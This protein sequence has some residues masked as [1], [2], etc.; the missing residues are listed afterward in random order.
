MPQISIVSGK[1]GTGKTTI[2]G[3]FSYLFKKSVIA[4]CDVDAADLHLIVDP[5]ILKSEIFE[6][7]QTAKIDKSKCAQCGTCI[8][9]CRFDAINDNFEIDPLACEGCGVCVWNCPA[10]AISMEP[11][12]SGEWYVSETTFGPLVHAK[13]GPGQENSGKL[14]TLVRNTASK[15]AEE[16]GLETVLIDGPPGIGCAAMASLTGVDSAL[17]V[18]EP[19]LSGAH[20]FKRIVELIHQFKIK[21]FACINKSDLNNDQTESIIRLC[22][23]KGVTF[24]GG[25]P[26]SL[27]V[28]KAMVNGKTIMEFKE[29][30]AAMAISQIWQNFLN[31]SRSSW[32]LSH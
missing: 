9:L 5:K 31:F 23:E 25:I 29:D 28:I 30:K 13:L 17:I 24:L 27:G 16:K 18:A 4:D 12:N 19:T 1:G 11:D 3:A 20:D 26:F 22:Q 21:G 15:I 7:G 10:T 32:A 14:V 6:G 2:T 8:E